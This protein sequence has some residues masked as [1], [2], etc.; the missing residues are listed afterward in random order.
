MSDT[1]H[2]LGG[3]THIVT[4]DGEPPPDRRAVLKFALPSALGILTFLTPVRVDGNW[5]ILMGWLTDSTRDWLGAGMA[6]IVFAL[7]VVSAVGTLAAVT[8]GRKWLDDGSLAWRL[9]HVSPVWV[10][11]RVLGL[12]MGAMTVF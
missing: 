7:L 1:P 9:F 5:T 2:D 8:I 10:V 11:L 4:D 6:W 3:D 12:I